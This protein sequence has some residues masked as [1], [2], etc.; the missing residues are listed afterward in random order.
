MQIILWILFI[1]LAAY[2]VRTIKGPSAWD[3]IV[4][5][6]LVTTKTIIIIMVFAS[7]QETTYLLDF[8]IIYALG[9]FIG[10]IFITMFLSARNKRKLKLE[11]ENHGERS[12]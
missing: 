5:L 4:G 11:R 10:T 6:N 2:I 9:G 8:A 1:F 3:R 7:M 12:I